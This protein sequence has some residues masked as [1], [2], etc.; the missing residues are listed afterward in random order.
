M[1]GVGGVNNVRGG[2]MAAKEDPVPEEDATEL[3]FGKGLYTKYLS[4]SF[5][6][7][8]LKVPHFNSRN[9]CLAK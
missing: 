7:K 9:S 4:S 3:R 5:F 8:C 6:L 2:N 1:A